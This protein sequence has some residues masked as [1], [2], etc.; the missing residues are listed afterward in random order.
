MALAA[1]Q[2]N[3]PIDV[4]IIRKKSG[5]EKILLGNFDVSM[6]T[7]KYDIKS[8]PGNLKELVITIPIGHLSIRDE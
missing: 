7:T 1:I 3:G 6:I 2:G 4:E 5:G 8:A